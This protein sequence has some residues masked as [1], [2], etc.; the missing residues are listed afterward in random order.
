MSTLV[1]FLKLKTLVI[2]SKS[3]L[4]NLYYFFFVLYKKEQSFVRKNRAVNEPTNI[5]RL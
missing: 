4:I 5:A 1:M 2:L 3:S